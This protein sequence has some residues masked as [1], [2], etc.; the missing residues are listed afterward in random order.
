MQSTVSRFCEFLSVK[1]R[2]VRQSTADPYYRVVFQDHIFG[3]YSRVGF[4]SST[5][6]QQLKVV[7]QEF[8]VYFTYGKSNVIYTIAQCLTLNKAHSQPPTSYSLN[9]KTGVVLNRLTLTLNHLSNR[10]RLPTLTITSFPMG[11]EAV[12]VATATHEQ[13]QLMRM[14]SL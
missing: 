12:C 14:L 7:L 4:Y 2:L 9:K 8:T 6:G 5:S 10:I 3:W 11:A 13:H 1:E